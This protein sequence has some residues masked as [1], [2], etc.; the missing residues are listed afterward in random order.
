MKVD[1]REIHLFL[2]PLCQ[3]IFDFDHERKMIFS[4]R[5]QS[6]FNFS[7]SLPTPNT[8]MTPI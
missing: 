3:E 8:P 5:L 6:N 4:V 7:K 2:Y 1:K